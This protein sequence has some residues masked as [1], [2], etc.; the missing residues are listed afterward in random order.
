MKRAPDIC[1]AVKYISST[2][3]S[4]NSYIGNLLFIVEGDSDRAALLDL[5][6]PYD[7]IIV[8]K[9]SKLDEVLVSRRS[10]GYRYVV[11][12]VDFDEEGSRLVRRIRSEAAAHGYIE[13]TGVRRRLRRYAHF[14]GY[15]IDAYF[16]NYMSYYKECIQRGML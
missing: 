14:F 9:Q 13:L 2:L 12:L 15:T 6:F 4:L 11:L 3:E 10:S 1:S 16:R 7:D 8:Y 5:G